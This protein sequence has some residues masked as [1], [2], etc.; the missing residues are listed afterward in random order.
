M[1]VISF[2]HNAFHK[3]TPV[4]TNHTSLPPVTHDM[5]LSAIAKGNIKPRLTHAYLQK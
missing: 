4:W 1:N 5:I 3:N 2:Q